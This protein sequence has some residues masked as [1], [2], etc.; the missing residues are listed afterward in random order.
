[1]VKL[2]GTFSQLSLQMSQKSKVP[3]N[4]MLRNIGDDTEGREEYF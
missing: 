3:E 4:K 1:M 2:A